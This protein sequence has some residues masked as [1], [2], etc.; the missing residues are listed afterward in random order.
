MDIDNQ[1]KIYADDN[2]YRK[3]CDICDNFAVDSYY[4]NHL[5][6]QS[7]LSNIRKRQLKNTSS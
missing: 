7:Q 6:S 5:R 3:Y 2:E 4:N 1:G